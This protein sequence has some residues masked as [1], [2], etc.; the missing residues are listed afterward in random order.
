MYLDSRGA[1]VY[2]IGFL[3]GMFGSSISSKVSSGVGASEGVP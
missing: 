1:K 2:V 3:H